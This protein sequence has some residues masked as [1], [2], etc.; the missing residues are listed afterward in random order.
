MRLEERRVEPLIAFAIAGDRIFLRD[1][2]FRAACDGF[3]VC[4]KQAFRVS[5][6]ITD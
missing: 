4:S 2:N 6:E 3:F 5:G 1:D